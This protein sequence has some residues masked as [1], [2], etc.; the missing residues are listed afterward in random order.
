MLLVAD[1]V[2]NFVANQGGLLY[3]YWA[4]GK[5]RN[6]VCVTHFREESSFA[7]YTVKLTVPAS[8]LSCSRESN[9]QNRK[10]KLYL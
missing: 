3:L 6:H 7:D 10:F 8:L 4:S 1:L 2:M 5:Y 9:R